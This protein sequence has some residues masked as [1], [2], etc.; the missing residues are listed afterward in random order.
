MTRLGRSQDFPPIEALDI[1][2]IAVSGE[3]GI[4]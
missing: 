1:S 3:G 4:A 2:N